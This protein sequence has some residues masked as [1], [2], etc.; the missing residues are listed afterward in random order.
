MKIMLT[1]TA[2][3]V[4]LAAPTWAQNAMDTDGDGNVSLEELQVA[5]PDATE[6][7]F[8]VLDTDGDGVLS[9]AEIL[10]ATEAGQ[11]PS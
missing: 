2:A 10:A 3:L 8:A 6:D 9:D 7:T 11:L 5:Y 1:T 4:A